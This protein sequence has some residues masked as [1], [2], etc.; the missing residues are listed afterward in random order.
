MVSS[1][2]R[3]LTTLP[4]SILLLLATTIAS[5]T[6][7]DT[8][9]ISYTGTISTLSTY[10]ASAFTGSQYT[11]PTLSSALP[12]TLNT[13]NASSIIIVSS[14]SPSNATATG[15]SSKST[16]KPSRTTLHGSSHRSTGTATTSAAG[17][18]NTVKCNGWT[19][20]CDRSYSNITY[21]CAHNSA[22]V[23]PNNAGSNQALPLRT[24]LDDGIRMV[25]GETHYVNGSIYNCHT[26]CKLLDVG[27]WEAEL[28]TVVDWLKDNPYEVLS[29]LVVNSDFVNVEKYVPAIEAS[30][31][32][33]Y[34]YVPKHEP[35][36]RD[37]WPTLGEMILTGK[38][39]VMYMDY[40]ANQTA[41][42]Y[43]LDE[44]SHM[45]ETP[46]SPTNRSFPC[47]QQ[48]PPGLSH[49]DAKNKLMYLANHNLN[50]PI[51]LS[52]LIGETDGHAQILIPNTADINIT[53]GAFDQFSQLEATRLNCTQMWDH[54]PNF[55]LVDYYN[56]GIPHPGSVF[57]VAARANGVAYNYDSCCG[58][59]SA[60]LASA[61]MRVSL[62]AVLV[63]ALGFSI[64]LVL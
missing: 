32:L 8:S 23:V 25:Q 20:F 3:K 9:S 22:F 2:P 33:P 39:V 57:E 48:R 28:A 38:R 30:G 61:S 60:S 62:A 52:A 55:L 43:I 12:T 41:V 54:P 45:W 21:V 1:W 31:I 34:L 15:S 53:N 51:D 19:E 47:T 26:T 27:L 11:Y 24:Q 42:P 14:N 4:P 50:T 10:S 44:F 49:A 13:N 58:K 18:S 56:Y 7:A 6:A 63:G 37:D 64:L 36:Y 16:T 17:P 46:F 59:T 35:Q 29:W 5:V 40:N